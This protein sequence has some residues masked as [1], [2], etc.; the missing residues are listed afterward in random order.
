MPSLFGIDIAN[1]IATEIA[2]AG[3]L[4]PGTLTKTTFGQRDPSNLAAG[5]SET[6]VSHTFQGFLE[7]GQVRIPD[8]RVTTSGTFVTILGASV[9]PSAVPEVNDSVTIEGSEYELTELMNRDPA[10]A[11]YMFRVQGG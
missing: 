4:V 3:N 2:K 5:R 7:K 10:A 11:T 9:V 8:S 1:V 6:S